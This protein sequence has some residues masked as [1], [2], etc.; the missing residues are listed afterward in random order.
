MTRPH[1]EFRKRYT[2]SINYR[3]PYDLYFNTHL[4]IGCQAW[5]STTINTCTV[6][7]FI[8]IGQIGQIQIDRDYPPG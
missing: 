5:T 6:Y 1:V 7:N 2:T 3:E 4:L 8:L